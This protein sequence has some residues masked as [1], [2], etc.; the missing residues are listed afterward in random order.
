MSVNPK[1]PIP[2]HLI[3]PNLANAKSNNG[4]KLPFNIIKVR[5]TFAN[6][7]NTLKTKIYNANI[8]NEWSVNLPNIGVE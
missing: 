7:K 8:N 1:R 2:R 5:Q 6:P 3:H 4:I